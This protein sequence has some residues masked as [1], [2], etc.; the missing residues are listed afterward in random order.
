MFPI[1]IG[2]NKILDVGGLPDNVDTQ[3]S[4]DFNPSDYICSCKDSD[5][6]DR[7]GIY[8]SFW[9]WIWGMI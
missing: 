7:Y 1:R 8:V 5:D 3:N 6:I 4:D 9:D 2:G